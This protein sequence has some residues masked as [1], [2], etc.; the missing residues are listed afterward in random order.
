MILFVRHG[1]TNLNYEKKTNGITDIPLN[2]NGFIQAKETAKLLAD[3]KIDYIFCS[4]LTRAQQTCAE[5]NRYHNLPIHT[6]PRL[7]ERNYGIY[8]NRVNTEENRKHYW[9][10]NENMLI[11]FGEQ[12]QNFFDR[13]YRFIDEINEKYPDKTVLVVAHGGVGRAFYSYFNGIP[14]DGC[15][16]GILHKNGSI[17]NY[18]QPKKEITIH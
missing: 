10:Y 16:L 17:M 3:K 6:D 15:L 8:E 1:E 12:V 2:N 18:E 5:I 9:N 7:M 4:P 14:S 13:I 11:P